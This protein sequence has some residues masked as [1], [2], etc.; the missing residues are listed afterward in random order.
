MVQ[1]AAIQ[2]VSTHD[3][4]ANLDEARKQLSD[5]AAKGAKVAVLPE[6]FAVL[7]TGQMLACGRQEAGD[8]PVIRH[9]LSEQA[10]G[11]GLWIVGGSMPLA[12]RPDGSNLSDRVRACCLVYNDEGEEVA[13]YDKI[14][15]FD[16]MIEDA[17]GQYRESDTFEPGNDVIVT[18]TPAGRLGLAICYDLRFP[19]LFRALRDKGADW[20]CLPSAFTWQTGD[21]HWHALLRA[22][23]IENQLWVVAA[24]Q[25]G[26]NSSRRRT[27]GHSL[28]CDPWGRVVCELGEGAGSVA[29]DLDLGDLGQLRSRMP[30]WAHRRL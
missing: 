28:I 14:H 7:A 16:A 18:E 11:L 4:E 3:I 20:V 23:A 19:E 30:V 15:L 12:V 21:A 26:Q 1:V 8:S 10:R 6:N 27:Y 13:R 29:A 22:R 5:V 2:M 9:F 25:G 17:H 24:G